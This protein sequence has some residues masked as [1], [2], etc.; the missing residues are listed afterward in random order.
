MKENNANA[1]ALDFSLNN[2]KDEQGNPLEESLLTER[3]VGGYPSIIYKPAQ[4]VPR[5]IAS[6]EN[7]LYTQSV[8][9]GGGRQSAFGNSPQTKNRFKMQSHTQLNS[10]RLQDRRFS[11]HQNIGNFG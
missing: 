10:D 7:S 6:R 1:L 11:S 5:S 3:S 4:K 8:Y 2:I 9:G